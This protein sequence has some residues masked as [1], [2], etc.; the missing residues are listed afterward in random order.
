MSIRVK[1]KEGRVAFTAPRGGRQIPHDRYIAVD[2]TPWIVRLLEHH[3]DIVQEPEAA[4]AKAP[5]FKQ[6]KPAVDPAPAA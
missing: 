5:A 4:S 2:K 3:G 6:A 1:A